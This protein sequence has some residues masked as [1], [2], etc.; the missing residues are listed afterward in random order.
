MRIKAIFVAGFAIG[1]VVGSRAGRERYDQLVKLSRQAA[2]S[3]PVQK[4]TA[5]VTAKTQDIAKSAAAKAPDLAKSAVPKIMDTARQAGARLPFGK[6]G[7]ADTSVAKGADGRVP[8]Q[9]ESPA[10]F[11]GIRAE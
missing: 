10:S 6:G 4:A 9:A 3:P 1:F 7:D 5:T 2:G 11:N 8:Q